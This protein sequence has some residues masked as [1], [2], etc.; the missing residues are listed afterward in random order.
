MC[1]TTFGT[2]TLAAM[3]ED[4]LIQAVMRSDGVSERDHRALLYRV[5]DKLT[6][7][8]GLFEPEPAPR[9]AMVE[10]DGAF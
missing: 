5:K 2:L 7:R 4:P 9:F 1:T 10:L 8:F 3:L 6:E